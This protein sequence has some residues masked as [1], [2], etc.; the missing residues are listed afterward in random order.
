[1]SRNVSFERTAAENKLAYAV[2][3]RAH[4][5]LVEVK[6]SQAP[7]VVEIV[8]DLIAVHANG[9]PL[10]FRKLAKFDDFNVMHDV[11]GINNHIDRKTG[12][13]RDCFRPR[14]AL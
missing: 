11:V 3:R 10:D 7:A 9:C 5:R 4:A 8:M 2:A 6:G 13:L 1:M 14:C 12:K